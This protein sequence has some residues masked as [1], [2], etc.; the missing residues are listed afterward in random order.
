MRPCDAGATIEERVERS[1]AAG[2][3]ALASD[4]DMARL[5]FV[6]APSAGEEIALALPRVAAALRHPAA[7]RRPRH[8]RPSRSLHLR[9]RV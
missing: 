5:L 1:L 4:P 3:D 7:L 6:E 2:L 9:S 8:A